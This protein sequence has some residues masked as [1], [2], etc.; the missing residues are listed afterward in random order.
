MPNAWDYD[1]YSFFDGSLDLYR[2]PSCYRVGGTGACM[3]IS[4]AA[5]EAGVT[6]SRFNNVSWWGEDRYFQ[7]H[8]QARGFDL[9]LDT[10]CPVF[11]IYRESL[12]GE[13]QLWKQNELPRLPYPDIRHK[14]RPRLTALM[15][16]RN[17]ANRYLNEVL[18]MLNEIADD[19][20]IVDDHSNDNTADLCETSPKTRVL[21]L[22]LSL[23]AMEHI[24]RELAWR[25]A[26]QTAPDWVLAIDADEIIE[27]PEGIRGL[28]LS[29]DV[30]IWAF[31]IFDMWD[32]RHYREDN[33][34][35]GHTRYTPMLLRVFPGFPYTWD[36]NKHH[37][38]RLPS[39]LGRFVIGKSDIRI[40]HLGWMRPE[41]RLAKYHRYKEMDPEG[42]WGLKEQY[43][44][45]LDENPRLVEW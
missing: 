35:N 11:H 44:S 33:Y 5:I 28:M 13:L 45:I 37:S 3:L 26:M 38:F 10:T 9:W 14:S 23:F 40:Q 32:P 43:E 16:V 27:H 20:A 18:Q 25:W 12:L 30:D 29:P 4:R 1:H 42:T 34:W 15:I 2:I 36:Q 24:L 8:A 19:I 41:D 6:Y 7:L 22:P 21:R 39:N 31:R 17:E